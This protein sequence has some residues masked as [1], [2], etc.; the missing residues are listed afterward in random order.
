LNH[1]NYLDARV[2]EVG[3]GCGLPSF[4]LIELMK[5]DNVSNDKCKRRGVTFS[6]NDD[7]VLHNLCN[8]FNDNYITQDNERNNNNDNDNEDKFL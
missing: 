3:C 2:L 6:D 4:L 8:L 7:E 5:K 1:K